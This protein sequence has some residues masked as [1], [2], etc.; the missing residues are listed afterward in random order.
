MPHVGTI[1]LDQVVLSSTIDPEV[2]QDSGIGSICNSVEAVVPPFGSIT[3]D[4]RGIGEVD[5][6]VTIEIRTS[7]TRCRKRK[8]LRE[9]HKHENIKSLRDRSEIS[10]RSF[11]RCL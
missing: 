7:N 6:S 10:P 4:Q 1:I 2:R 8:D 11:L 3:E 9:E 5:G